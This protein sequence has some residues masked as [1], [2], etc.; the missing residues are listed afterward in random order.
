MFIYVITNIINGKQYVGQT[1]GKIKR[2]WGKHTN[3]RILEKSITAIA[4]AIA[5]YGKENF[6]IESICTCLS[7]SELNQ[8]E[9]FYIKELDTLYPNGY[10]LTTGGDNHT[11]SDDSRKKMSISH[12]NQNIKKV[13]QI[14]PK[15]FQILNC[16]KSY[17]EAANTLKIAENLISRAVKV[18][19][20]TKEYYWI[21]EKDFLENQQKL[22]V[23]FEKKKRIF[24]KEYRE[25]ISKAN[26]GKKLSE[27]VKENLRKIHSKTWI[28]LDPT[29]MLVTIINLHKFCE[30][31]KISVKGLTNV[32]KGK[33]KEHKGWT[34]PEI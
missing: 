20:L 13:Y 11:V 3:K 1:I 23:Y 16:F 19:G 18:K 21:S 30:E 12:L 24:S 27:K 9:K 4:R 22:P 34:K 25:K 6:K 17:R 32:F 8:K 29:G 5:K 2:R 33:Q 28:F 7:L 15:T 14:C 10:N 31:N 26:K